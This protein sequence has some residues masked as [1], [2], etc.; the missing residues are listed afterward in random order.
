[1]L[2][3]PPL[4]VVIKNH[5]LPISIPGE[6]MTEAEVEQVLA[7]HEDANGCINYEGIRH[8]IWAAVTAG[9]K[10]VQELQT[11]RLGGQSQLELSGSRSCAPPC[12]DR[13]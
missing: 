5:C 9:A 4:S 11:P 12:L 2:P 6:K 3:D 10:R 7:G 8:Q 13:Q 1:M